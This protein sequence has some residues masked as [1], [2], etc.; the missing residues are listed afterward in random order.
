[1][2]QQLPAGTDA[3]FIFAHNEVHREVVGLTSAAS[4]YDGP[5]VLTTGVEQ[6]PAVTVA[7]ATTL[8]TAVNAV[9]EC[10]R[11][12]NDH[13]GRGNAGSGKKIY[14]HKTAD[15]ANPVA[16]ADMDAGSTYE[17]ALL[18]LLITMVNELRLD[19]TNHGA[20]LKP[21]GTAS[22]VHAAADTTNVLGGQPTLTDY[23]G[24]AD[25]LNLL[26]NTYNDHIAFSSG[27][28][29]HL[30]PDGSNAVSAANALSTDI[31]S[32]ITLANQIKAKLTAHYSQATVH[33][34]SDTF[35]TIA[36]ADVA[37]PAGL[38]TLANALK[39]AYN[40]HRASTTYHESADST[41]AISSS[42]ASTVTSLI[43][44]AAELQ[45]DLSAHLRRAPVTRAVR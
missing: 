21:D 27:G 41:N 6:V 29:P 35:N 24:V 14:A 18:A 7:T 39:A 42:D 16:T 11:L 8:T 36:T 15:A 12:F 38:Y 30:N 2:A 34:A 3:G 25:A 43:T 32:C 31:D 22:G 19:F 17:A 33:S 1:M 20:N 23:A 4:H 10:K 28:S 37:Y 45:T 13:C 40:L 9:N 26:K 44:L 5:E